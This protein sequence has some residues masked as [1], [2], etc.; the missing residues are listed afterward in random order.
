MTIE[1]KV[2]SEAVRSERMRLVGFGQHPANQAG[3]VQIIQEM[4]KCPFASTPNIEFVTKTAQLPLS[5]KN[6]AAAL[7]ETVNLLDTSAGGWDDVATS[8]VAPN[9]LQADILVTGIGVHAYGEPETFTQIG[10]AFSV[11]GS[12]PPAG[13]PTPVSADVMSLNDTTG[14]NAQ[15]LM[16]LPVG[17][18]LL[19]A[20]LEWGH[21]AWM[22]LWHLTNA[23][24]FI[25][26]Y[27]QRVNLVE[28]LLADFCYFGPY[29]E[30]I[31]SGTND[32]D[33]IEYARQ[34]NNR[35]RD[36]GGSGIFL[37]VNFRR[38]GSVG[39]APLPNGGTG[40]VA[41]VSLFHPT[42]DF[43]LAQAMQGGL[44]N[45]GAGGCCAPFRRFRPFILEAGIPIGLQ[46][47]SA[48]GYHREQM[49]RYFSISEN[50]D[51]NTA[52]VLV[53]ENDTGVSASGPAVA[54]EL[55]LDQGVN[56][57]ASNQVVTSR[58][59]FKGGVIKLAA[60]IKGY[61]LW[62]QYKSVAIGMGIP[63]VG[64]VPGP[65]ALPAA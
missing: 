58:Q 32:V 36:Q 50:Q 39:A 40:I 25:F 21:A 37:P 64:K 55:T 61:V 54:P 60:L 2:D 63:V 22:G 31:G 52:N 42:R 24:K 48:S 20:I 30:G 7:P 14:T 3:A 59:L 23:Y 49:L 19:P 17:G 5:D 28:E 65:A 53:D 47:Q 4:I 57:Y 35:Y 45:Q 11:G 6:L 29:A 51:G 46:L 1:S 9:T 41:P 56:Q 10:N 13:T 15:N 34:A 33:V 16:G 8:F 12:P 26:K 43:D 44:R 62:G 18:S 27:R 38:E